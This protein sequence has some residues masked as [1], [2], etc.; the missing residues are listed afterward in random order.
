[1]YY[2]C[3]TAYLLL[4]KYSIYIILEFS[5]PVVQNS[6]RMCE[7]CHHITPAPPPCTHNVISCVNLSNFRQCVLI[8]NPELV[9]VLSRLAK[10][11]PHTLHDASLLHAACR[12]VLTSNKN[13]R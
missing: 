9:K 6:M 10:D 13:N 1:M 8:N 3:T 4:A 2:T 12:S 7:Q 5:L 11:I